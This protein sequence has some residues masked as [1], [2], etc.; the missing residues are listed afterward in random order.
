MPPVDQVLETSL[1][2]A[3]LEIAARFY[4]RVFGFAEV[5][6]EENRMRGL[7]VG[8]R[9]VLLLFR[10]GGSRQPTQAPGGVIPPHDGGGHLHLAFAIPAAAVE[11]W[12]DHLAACGVA[13]ESEVDTPR[14]GR[15][16]YF[17][18]PDGHLLE[19]VTP[20]TWPFY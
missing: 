11:Q 6:R 20:G 1:Y 5:Y 3:D 16:L 15:S 9:Q 13:I 17:R 10:A 7:S 8:D 4:A 18:D 2:V 14:G 19:L 12:R